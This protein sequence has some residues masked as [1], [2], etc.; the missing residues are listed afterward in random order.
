[1]FT[2]VL[3]L[4]GDDEIGLEGGYFFGADVF[5]ASYPGLG[6][7]PFLRVDAEFGDTDDFERR[8]MG[9]GREGSDRGYRAVPFERAR[10]R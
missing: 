3:F 9:N 6:A 4:I 10:G 2:N 5:G 7:K 8:G 1:L